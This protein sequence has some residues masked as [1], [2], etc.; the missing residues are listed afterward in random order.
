MSSANEVAPVFSARNRTINAE[1][2]IV[3]T[4][5]G[6]DIG[7]STSHLALSRIV[8]QR[9][10]SRYAVKT[11][12][13]LFESPMMLTPYIT[14]VAIDAERLSA[15]F[16]EQYRAAGISMNDIDTGALILTGVAA[17]RS[18]ARAIGEALALGAGKLVALSAGDHLESTL[19]AFGSGAVQMSSDEGLR[20]MAIDIGGGTSKVAVCVGGEIVDRVVVDIGARLICVDSADD[21]LRIETAGRRI[22][23]EAGVSLAPGVTL[24][25]RSKR[26][27]AECMA[28]R[29]FEAIGARRLSDDSVSWLRTAP[30]SD[31]TRPDVV[32]LSGGVSEYLYGRET[33]SFGDLGPWLANAIRRR[34]A[35]WGAA[36]RMP[37]HGIRATVMG[38]SQYTVQLSGSTIFVDPPNTLPLRNLMTIEP[39]LRLDD[40]TLDRAAIAAKVRAALEQVD[41]VSTESGLAVSVHWQGSASYHRLDALCRGLLGGLAPAL[42][43][44]QPLV[45][46]TDSDI[47]GLIG[48]HCRRECG[49]PN[50]IVSIDTVALGEL[51]FIDI[52]ELLDSSGAVPV[53]VKSLLF[54]GS[55]LRLLT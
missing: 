34:L 10:G 13:L 12:E 37:S 50:A 3:L 17:Q 11:R 14:D 41:N 7:S 39:K 53:V 44:G 31:R 52:G 26:A 40:D 6:V 29:L 28:D 4:T 33:R 47:G 45:I 55:D 30:L 42:N 19:V 15:F 16:A 43:R 23:E 5:V 54:A 36:T 21:V 25:D 38:A 2:E 1:D 35:D 49:L 18:N 51:D 32:L 9:H 22:A 46:I 20:V 24:T 48:I 27:I 8:M